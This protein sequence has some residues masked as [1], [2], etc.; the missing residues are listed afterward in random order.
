MLWPR[1][2]VGLATGLAAAL[3][4]VNVDALWRATI[5]RNYAGPGAAFSY[6]AAWHDVGNYLRGALAL[7]PLR[8]GRWAVRTADGRRTLGLRQLA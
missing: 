8:G 5:K 7:E 2:A 1:P 3:M 4:A 6:R